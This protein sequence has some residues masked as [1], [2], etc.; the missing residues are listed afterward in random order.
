MS[1]VKHVL[2]RTANG[3]KEIKISWRLKIKEFFFF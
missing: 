3:G 1:Q 2:N